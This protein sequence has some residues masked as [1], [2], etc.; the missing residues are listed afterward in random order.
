[1]N[2][3]FQCSLTNLFLCYPNRL[4]SEC[5]MFKSCVKGVWLASGRSCHVFG[6]LDPSYPSLLNQFLCLLWYKTIQYLFC[7]CLIYLNLNCILI[8]DRRQ[9][10]VE[11]VD[12]ANNRQ[13]SAGV[14]LRHVLTELL[15]TE[16]IYVTE[17]NLILNVY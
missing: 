14:K 5:K 6:F 1:M 13:S 3:S 17:I 12:M 16:R 8:Q 9:S 2:Y 11:S 7:I 4:F 10:T 15:E